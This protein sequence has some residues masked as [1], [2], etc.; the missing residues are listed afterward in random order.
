MVHW[1]G[2]SFLVT[3]INNINHLPRTWTVG[4]TLNHKKCYHSP[5]SRERL[6]EAHIQTRT[7][8]QLHIFLISSHTSPL[9]LISSHLH[10]SLSLISSLERRD[11]SDSLID[12]AQWNFQ[13]L[14]LL[15]PVVVLGLRR[16]WDQLRK[17]N[18]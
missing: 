18:E 8:S 7:S 1:L 14:R 13:K 6:G 4:A 15:V 12:A 3:T 16:D 10:L 17:G 2:S 5:F 11:L 9:S